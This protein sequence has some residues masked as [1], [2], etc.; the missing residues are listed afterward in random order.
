MLTYKWWGRE[1]VYMFQQV[2]LLNTTTSMLSVCEKN[3]LTFIIYISMRVCEC[4]YAYI[5]LFESIEALFFSLIL[6]DDDFEKCMHTL[7][8]YIIIV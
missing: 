5:E 2:L 3:I 8:L 7:Y 4:M 1:Q 6:N